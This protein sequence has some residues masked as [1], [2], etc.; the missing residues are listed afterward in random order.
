MIS[1]C[2]SCQK[3][4]SGRL[5]THLEVISVWTVI[6]PQRKP[7]WRS[8]ILSVLG[9]GRTGVLDSPQLNFG[10][11][12]SDHKGVLSN[13]LSELYNVGKREYL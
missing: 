13:A 6:P 11:G 8:S 12:P 10:C 1:E 7:G 3:L 2:P 9:D 5:V 4:R